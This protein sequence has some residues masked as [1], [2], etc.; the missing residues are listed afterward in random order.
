MF[1]CHLVQNT[2]LLT[3]E[4]VTGRAAWMLA[5]CPTCVLSAVCD[6][7]ISETGYRL[8]VPKISFMLITINSPQCV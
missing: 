6:G 4:N 5:L 1:S 3:K 2:L 7:V 8:F